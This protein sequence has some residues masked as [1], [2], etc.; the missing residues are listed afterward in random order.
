VFGVFA[1]GDGLMLILRPRKHLSFW[2]ANAAGVMEKMKPNLLERPQPVRSLGM[3]ELL[4]GLG[5]MAWG[6]SR[7]VRPETPML[8][9]IPLGEV[10]SAGAS[11]I[12]EPVEEEAK[13]VR[14]YHSFPTNRAGQKGYH[15]IGVIRR[16]P[17][18]QRYVSS[19]ILMVIL[20]LRD[21]SRR[22]RHGQWA[23]RG[24]SGTSAAAHRPHQPGVDD[25]LFWRIS[26][27]GA[28]EPFNSAIPAWKETPDE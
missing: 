9:Y 25:Y 5:L 27:G 7:F 3:A 12:E 18:Q 4:L 19:A 11:L 14:E 15:K 22:R 6:A 26:E 13:D 21:V 2:L 17:R 24:G 1:I 23:G 10:E 20:L 8:D 16:R 28:M